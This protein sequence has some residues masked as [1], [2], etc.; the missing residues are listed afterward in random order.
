ME[1]DLVFFERIL[2][3]KEE[4]EEQKRAV[5]VAGAV[6]VLKPVALAAVES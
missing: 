4:G 1:G 5:V 3:V 6:V 2:E